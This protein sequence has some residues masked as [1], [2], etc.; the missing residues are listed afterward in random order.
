MNHT[1]S[2]RPIGFGNLY[3]NGDPR[4]LKADYSGDTNDPVF[5]ISRNEVIH[6]HCVSATKMKGIAGTASPYIVRNHL[7]T[8]EGAVLQVLMP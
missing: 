1:E 5:D 6:A 3:Y 2:R 4:S 7:E 8:N